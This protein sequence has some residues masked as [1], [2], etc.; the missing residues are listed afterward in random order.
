MWHTQ[1]MY[2]GHVDADEEMDFAEE[3]VADIMPSRLQK[4]ARSR[5]FFPET[6]IWSNLYNV[7]YFF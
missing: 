5:A 6:W 4:V 7:R 1:Y 2:G 3:A